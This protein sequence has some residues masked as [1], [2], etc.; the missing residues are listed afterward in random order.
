MI[1]KY[2]E[3]VTVRP[4]SETIDEKASPV[5][6]F[7]ESDWFTTKALLYDRSGLSE[8]WL[9]VGIDEPVDYIAC[10]YSSLKDSL[11]VHDIVV[12]SD[13]TK[14]EIINILERGIGFRTLFLE[15]FLRRFE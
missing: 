7:P 8:E 12:L 11:S 15:V 5:F 1:S 2:G 4:R 9:V 3:D 13:G 14:T 10:F 6:T